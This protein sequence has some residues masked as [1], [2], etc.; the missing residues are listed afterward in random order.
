MIAA[1]L[2]SPQKIHLQDVAKPVP[3]ANQVLIRLK[4]VG[5][6]G[7]DV[8]L[9]L[10]DR[11]LPEPTILGHEGIGIVESVGAEVSHLKP[12]DRVL[13]EPN[14]AC[15]TCQYCQK[16]RGNIC[17][18][19]KV[20][21][22][23]APGCF[24]Q[25]IALEAEYCW[26]IPDELTDNQAVCVEPMAVAVH[27][28]ACSSVQK[29]ASIAVFGLGAIGLLLTQIALAAGLNVYVKDLNQ[30]KEQFAAQIGACILPSNEHLAA[31][32]LEKD[33]EA[34]FDCVGVAKATN[35]ILVTAPRGSEI[36]LVG[37]ANEACSFVPLR[38]ARE[39]I[40]IL[41][42]IIY[43][44]PTDF[45]ATIELIQKRVVDP[46][47]IISHRYNLENFEEAIT[48]A[49]SGKATKVIIDI[50]HHDRP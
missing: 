41:P 2:V 20:I 32:M 40:A 26:K 22:V 43:K 14:V 3:Q 6:C 9:Y 12:G 31:Y 50:P 23:N 49:S 27:A 5:I 10:G 17:I 29:G 15:G 45:Q 30:E 8:H 4:S 38:I 25:F 1:V 7:S 42:S 46:S 33:I 39:E 19:K 35:L 36:V 24:T 11:P 28:L 48:L 44:H 47:I 16:G 37:L 34:I 18:H 13:I 21:G